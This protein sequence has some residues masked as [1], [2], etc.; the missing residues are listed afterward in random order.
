MQNENRIV[1][2]PIVGLNGSQS[3][4]P[5]GKV[6]TKFIN[7]KKKFFSRGAFLYLQEYRLHHRRQRV[8]P[9][10][11]IVVATPGTLP[12]S[13][14]KGQLQKRMAG[15]TG[16]SSEEVFE[17]IDLFA[18]EMQE[19]QLLCN[20][21]EPDTQSKDLAD[22]AEGDV[23]DQATKMFKHVSK[24]HNGR[25]LLGMG[26]TA[27]VSA[28]HPNLP[29]EAGV[30]HAIDSGFKTIMEE[31][32]GLHAVLERQEVAIENL[33]RDVDK[34]RKS[35]RLDG[36]LRTIS[37]SVMTVEQRLSTN[38]ISAKTKE[39]LKKIR[40][41]FPAESVEKLEEIFMMPKNELDIYTE[42]IVACI[43]NH[44]NQ[45]FAV[46]VEKTLTV[47]AMVFAVFKHS[48]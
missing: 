13:N 1:K 16:K 29:S 15:L 42:H 38:H 24:D 2:Q 10:K 27:N 35:R 9:K 21:G 28:H 20:Q 41:Q 26:S 6:F 31:F 47:D 14:V 12:L 22:S 18:T 45:I 36:L 48:Q 30:M 3:R 40:K 17:S 44:S 4:Q 34:V 37:A 23:G 11:A 43:N 25:E 32:R 19:T 8:N 33:Q 46:A 39:V 5:G 7:M